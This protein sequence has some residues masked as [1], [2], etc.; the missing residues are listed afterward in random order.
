MFV[1]GKSNIRNI[2][3]L[4]LSVFL[5]AV[6]MLAGP[7]AGGKSMPPDEKHIALQAAIEDLMTTF[8]D[9][10][11]GGREYLTKLNSMKRRMSEAGQADIA[12]IQTD[13]TYLQREALIAN[14]LVS[15]Q[16]ILFIMRNQYK[17]DHHNTATMFKTGEINTNSFQGGGAMKT[18]DFAKG[19]EVRMLIES[20][21]GLVRDPEIH[22]SG[23]KIVFSMRKNINDDYHIYEINADGS[24]LKQLTSAVGV[25]DFD[26]LYMP[27]DTIVFS[28]TREPKYC[29]CNRHIMGN[30]FRMDAD[31]ANIHQVGKSTLHEGH[32][33]LMPDGRIIYDRWEY[34][35][36]N[37]GDA[38][39]LWI[40]NPDG[41]N[42]CIYWGN[43]T[44]SPG[45][46]IDAR[47][48]QGTQRILCVFSS[49]HDRPWGA[50]AIIDR[51]LGGD[52]REPV[53]RTWPADAIDLVKEKGPSPDTYGFDNF[54][55]VNPKYED[56]FPLNDKYFLCSRMTGRG[57][58]M[59]IYLIDL[60][61]NEVLL[62]VEPPGCYDPMPLGPRPRPPN[63]PSRRSFRNE[64]GYV[65]V[66]NVYEGTHMEG[67]K[68]G[69]VK[70]L[71]VV[72]SPE[73]RF[74]TH[75]AWGG[76]GVHCPAM[77]WHSFENKRILGTVPVAE[78]GSAYFEVP[79]DK[80]VFFQLLDENKMMIQSMRSGTIVQSG[81]RTGC[82]GCHENRRSAPP[83]L[84]TNMP[85]ALQRPPSKL[86][87]W[88]GKPRLFSYISEV[89]PVF[90]R[91]CVSCHDYGKEAGEKLNL[92][93]DRTN[94]FNTSYN[95]LWRKNYIKAIGAGPADVQQPYSWGSHASKLVKVIRQGHEDVKLTS[96]EFET[97]AAWIDINA[98]YYP[99]YD[100]AYP[101]NLAGRSPLDSKQINRLTELTGVPFAKLANYNTNLGTQVSFDRPEISPCLQKF[102]DTSGPEYSEALAIIQAGSRT[103]QKRPRADM[104]GFQACLL[105]RRRQQVYTMRQQIEWRNRR[106]IHNG[107]KL[108]EAPYR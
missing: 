21:E 7:A 4:T 20:S 78:D 31:G 6:A 96:A 95:E 58:Q 38:Q 60:F 86:R 102:E 3:A 57:E 68:P 24:G 66:V 67:I 26:P 56:P 100:S 64:Q 9:R 74:W 29:M 79:S 90:D 11:P 69:T 28:S 54:K 59:G 49:C 85:I 106:A 61:G 13:F 82:T 37:F 30:L 12:K 87:G 45:A 105:D 98:P 46:V 8:G 84:N 53:V 17:S 18:I 75:T 19:G 50:L 89:Q 73:K 36:R 65:Y 25:A 71:R 2:Y 55:S 107:R 80:F 91:H 32:S 41:T 40:V 44:W 104:D 92:A 15:G 48:L 99:R 42:H 27:D 22:F 33:A 103:L 10:Y 35:D 83:Q 62:H 51:R 16:P 39:G 108:Y 63:I 14:P 5:P 23:R 70:Y 97:I 77:N 88:H 1:G 76:Q 47:A 34:V 52:G 93:R 81:E 94:T 101:D 43:N 72:E